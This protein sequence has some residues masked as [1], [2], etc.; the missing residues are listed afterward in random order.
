MSTLS[1]RAKAALTPECNQLSKSIKLSATV[2]LVVIGL[3]LILL[4]MA[5]FYNYMKKTETTEEDN[6]KEKLIGYLSIASTL[7]IGVDL[8]ASMWQYSIAS[9]TTA[10]CL[11]ASN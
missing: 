8:L 3:G 2:L 4:V 10:V 7:I 5:T 9:R 1:G 11:T 6:K